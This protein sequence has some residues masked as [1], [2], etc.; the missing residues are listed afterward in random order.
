MVRK[1]KVKLKFKTCTQTCRGNSLVKEDVLLLQKIPV[2]FPTS[3]W[4]S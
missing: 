1:Y 2:Q 4:S 3:I